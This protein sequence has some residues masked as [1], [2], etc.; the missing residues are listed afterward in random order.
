MNRTILRTIALQSCALV[1]ALGATWHAQAQEIKTPY[2]SMAPLDQYLM[3]RNAEITLARSAAPESISRD[4]EVMVSG[5]RGYEPA[6]KGKNDF[7]CV[8]ERSWT[9]PIDS[10]EFWNPKGRAPVC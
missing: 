5:P 7:V 8:V 3:D 10:P 2:P 9:S 4:A 6:V 1:A